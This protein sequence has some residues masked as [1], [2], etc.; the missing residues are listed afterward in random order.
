MPVSQAHTS[1]PFGAVYMKLM[2][3]PAPG[4]EDKVPHTVSLPNLLL[5]MM[6]STPAG[7]LEHVSV[8]S[9]SVAPMIFEVI[10]TPGMRA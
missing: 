9:R 3:H 6:T 1:G 8:P 5:L 2:V 4:H 7:P 10:V